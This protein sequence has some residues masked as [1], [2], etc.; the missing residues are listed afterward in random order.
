MRE[1]ASPRG[2]ASAPMPS[3]ADLREREVKLEAIKSSLGRLAH[4]FNSGLVPILGYL[5][6]IRSDLGTETSVEEYL[7]AMERSARNNVQMAELILLATRPQRKFS[8]TTFDLEQ[9]IG[10]T[11]TEFLATQPGIAMALELN[12]ATIK[13]DKSQWKQLVTEL[14]KNACEAS[15]EGVELRIRL[16]IRPTVAGEAGELGM[17]E[18][19]NILELTVSDQGTGIPNEAE[20]S[21]IFEPFYTTRQAQLHKGLGLTVVH[22]IVRLNRGQVVASNNELK[23]F[24]MNILLPFELLKAN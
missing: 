10:E 5:S 1:G 21:R 8:A 7:E 3:R 2:T 6:M 23:G 12:P 18:T 19:P 16:R 15:P 11:V 20:Q 9:Q 22:G 14:L 24:R 17:P 4:D 13:S